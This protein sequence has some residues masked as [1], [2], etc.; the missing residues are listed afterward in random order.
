MGGFAH[1]GK[2]GETAKSRP[3]WRPLL[4]GGDTWQGSPVP[5]YGQM[6]RIWLMPL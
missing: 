3:S 1:Y 5:L 2:L 4:D 6:A